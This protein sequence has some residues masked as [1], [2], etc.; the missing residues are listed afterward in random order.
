MPKPEY[1]DVTDDQSH[2]HNTSAQHH[3]EKNNDPALD[4]TNEHTH[5]HLHHSARAE[6]DR[7]QTEYSKGTTYEESNIP[8][9][10]PHDQSVHR[11]HLS[12]DPKAPAAIADTEKGNFSPDRS[13][14]DPRTHKL[15]NVYLK[16]RIFVHVFIW[17][18][19]TGFVGS[20]SFSLRSPVQTAAIPNYS[21]RGIAFPSIVVFQWSNAD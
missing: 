11:R 2:T 8:S 7:D 21:A 4:P 3:V 1:L 16:Y 18:V 10:D 14:D 12:N 13:D 19:F 20:F 5:G 17:L 9:Q 6:Q 15:S